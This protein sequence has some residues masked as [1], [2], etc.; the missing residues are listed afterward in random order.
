MSLYSSRKI[1]SFILSVIMVA[2]A[3]ILTATEITVYTLCSQIYM[4][5]F[6]K[7]N[8]IT[9]K[10]DDIY[11]ERIN[12]LSKECNIPDRVFDA[13]DE[14]LGDY[15]DTAVERFFRGNNSSFYSNDL[16]ETYEKLFCEYLD[17]NSLEYNEEDIHNAAE[18]AARIYSD[19]YGL[20]NTVSVRNF[21]DK[22]NSLQQK[23]L[24]TFIFL[25]T[26]SAVFVAVLYSKKKDIL[27]VFCSTFTGYGLSLILISII[28]LIAGVGQNALVTPSFYSI[29][30]GNAIRGAFV[31]ALFTGICAAA[32]S[33]W[34]TLAIHKRSKTEKL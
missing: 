9:Q 23:I 21:I 22:V 12:A 29:A 32:V 2:C 13:V 17:G 20:S 4:E 11:N 3:I 18:K 7:S 10:C 6:F 34:G 26:L 1:L 30:I 19:S 28:S 24:S 25:F 33:V 16:V 14:V 15:S 8:S 5:R 31:I 27:Q